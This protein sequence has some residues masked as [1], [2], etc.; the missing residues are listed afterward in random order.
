MNKDILLK[1]FWKISQYAIPIAVILLMVL[2]IYLLFTII[3]IVLCEIEDTGL[4][5]ILEQIWYGKGG[6]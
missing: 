2:V 6:S 3:G 5:L 4:K 1:W